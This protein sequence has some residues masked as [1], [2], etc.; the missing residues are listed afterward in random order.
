LSAARAPESAAEAIR[1]QT[2]VEGVQTRLVAD[3]AV[4]LAGVEDPIAG[5]LLSLPERGR[6]EVNAIV[7]R[8]DDRSAP[9]MRRR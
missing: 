7:L 5:R 1:R 2:G 3:V 8:R 4:G 6:P 9:A